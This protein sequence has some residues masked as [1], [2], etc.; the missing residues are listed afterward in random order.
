MLWLSYFA[1]QLQFQNGVDKYS[2]LQVV[3]ANTGSDD[4]DGDIVSSNCNVTACKLTTKIECFSHTSQQEKNAFPK[5]AT[6][7]CIHWFY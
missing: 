4:G 1:I 6:Q 3:C 5:I 2:L 7:M